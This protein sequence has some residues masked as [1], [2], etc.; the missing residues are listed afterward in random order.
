MPKLIVNRKE[1][2][3]FSKKFPM[4]RHLS[5][6]GQVLRRQV[7]KNVP[8]QVGGQHTRKILA[9]IDAERVKQLLHVGDLRRP[10][11]GKYVEQKILALLVIPQIKL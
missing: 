9:L 2:Y 1:F 5:T 7:G 10:Q 8:R 3:L 6:P 11:F 4:R